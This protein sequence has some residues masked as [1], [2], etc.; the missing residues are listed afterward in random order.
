MSRALSSVVLL[1]ACGG[2]QHAPPPVA[3]CNRIGAV[4]IVEQADVDRVAGCRWMGSLTIKTGAPLD[5]SPLE[6]ERI[7]GDVNVGP[8]LALEELRLDHLRA[9]GGAIR[10]ESNALLHGV[11]LPQLE[12]TRT[13]TI[14]AGSALAT[15]A[16]PKLVTV[17]DSITIDELGS[18]EILDFSAVETIGGALTI[19]HNPELTLVQFDALKI[20]KTVVIEANDKLP[21]DQVDALRARSPAATD[22]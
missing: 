14:E 6:V 7:T 16:A 2:S 13:F 20:V 12:R 3:N 10:V 9:V 5:L 17:N 1:A 21:A 18:V 4:S 8:T 15:I 11:F 22:R 19:T